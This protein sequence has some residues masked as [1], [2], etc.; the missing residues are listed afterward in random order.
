MTNPASGFT[1]PFSRRAFLKLGGLTSL[2]VALGG[3]GMHSGDPPGWDAD[4]E[5][6]PDKIR[7]QVPD[8]RDIG[9]M[10][11][12][13]GKGPLR[14]MGHYW[15]PA[16]RL[17]AGERLPAVVELNPY[18]RRDGT[19]SGDST[20]YP[21]F[22][23]SGY[24]AFRVDLQGSGDS[25]GVMTD[26]YTEDEITYCI[27]VIEQIAGLPFCNGRVGMLG[28]SWSAINSLMV[29]AHERCPAALRAVLVM[30][31]SDDRYNDDVHYKGGAMMQDNAGWAASMWGWL[32]LPPDP[33]VV[34]KDWEAM[35][36]ERIRNATFW[37]EHW[38]SHPTRDEYW[39]KR[40][41]RDHLDQVKVPVFILS[42][43]QDGY[44]NPVP[45]LVSA[46]AAQGKP[47]SGLL[48]PWGHS[49]PDFGYPG[50]RLNWLPYMMRHWWDRWLK[51]ITPHPAKE[52]PPLTVW[53]GESREPTNSP[54]FDEP[55]RWVAEDGDWAARVVEQ[56]LFL[57][58]DGSLDE[59]APPAQ[60]A[61]SMARGVIAN[62][63]HLENGSWGKRDDAD[64]PGDQQAADAQSLV[65]DTL[66]LT[67]DLDCF[68][69]PRVLL[70]LTCDQPL[71]AIVIRLS[72]VS[73]TTGA[74]NLVSY[75][76]RNLCQLDDDQINPEPIEPG[77]PFSVTV[78]LDV[79]GHTFK[80]G[81]RI[82][83]AIAPSNFPTL[84][85]SGAFPKIT[86]HTGAP[87]PAV[88]SQLVLP[89]RPRRTAD[90]ELPARLPSMTHIVQVDAEEYLPTTEVRASG[91]TRTTTPINLDGRPGFLVHKVFDSG[92]YIYGGPLADL[93][94]DQIG[95]ENH[96]IL[97]DD[98]DSRVTFTQY[99][100]TLA[101]PSTN[102]RVRTET[103]TRV[104]NE[105]SPTGRRLFKYTAEI[106]T[107]ILGKD[108][109][110][111]PFEQRAVEGAIE[112]DC[113]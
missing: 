104:W 96:R 80:Q 50:P 66:P 19:L 69:Y 23:A 58:S 82:R 44:K 53:L 4:E 38:I 39:T 63:A 60:G 9:F 72:E 28:T 52:L 24:L 25:E 11:Q 61:V 74:V 41:V 21:Y 89:S 7:S 40:S 8:P 37:F 91:N 29:A 62:F 93:A 84:W 43:Y 98:P 6:D 103:A 31:G 67:A 95:E 47:V 36:R 79:V 87:S 2:S 30:C 77:I 106:Q 65:F 94:V 20:W 78:P 105:R 54:N 48:G 100:A 76:F 85:E 56:P 13:P 57:W 22:A 107:F 5:I 112:V 1:S 12:A 108:G 15:Y 55:G 102:W 101:R 27:Q 59:T 92:H 18:R 16:A 71:A 42:G 88:A 45:R 64:L 110:E 83:L 10:V 109:S 111:Q 75:S 32:T 70:T 90:Q 14:L 26:E 73:P 99:R 97:A 49:S 81:W 68:G 35:W 34:G 17:A 51:G 113:L 33:L 46:L 3:C 86:V